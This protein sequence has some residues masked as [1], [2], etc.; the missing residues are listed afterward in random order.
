MDGNW[1]YF[2]TYSGVKLPLKLV[3]PLPESEL[4]FRDTF[5]RARFDGHDRIVELEKLVHGEVQMH[6]R[7]DYSAEGTLARAEITIG[8]ESTVREF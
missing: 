1:R 3:H 6:H 2:V 4:S 7:Y 8:D 5:L